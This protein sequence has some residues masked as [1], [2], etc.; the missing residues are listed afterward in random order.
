MVPPPMHPT[1]VPG[2]VSVSVLQGQM[3]PMIL[4]QSGSNV[5]GAVLL[6]EDTVRL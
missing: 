3:N 4:S 6:R 2:V 1:S 5:P